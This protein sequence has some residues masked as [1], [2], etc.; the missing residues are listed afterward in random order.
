MPCNKEISKDLRSITADLHK[1]GKGYKVISKSLGIHQ[2]TVR[3]IVF[4]WAQC[5]M[6]NEVQKSPRVTAK[7]LK[8]T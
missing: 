4:N 8:E 6:L 2:L 1:V 5:R 3:E 7:G